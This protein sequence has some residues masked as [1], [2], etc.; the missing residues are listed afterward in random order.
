MYPTSCSWLLRQNNSLLFPNSLPVLQQL[1]GGIHPG[2]ILELCG[3]SGI[4]KS[5]ICMVLV[6]DCLKDCKKCVIVSNRNIP[7]KQLRDLPMLQNLSVCYVSSVFELL[8]TL[9]ALQSLEASLVVIEGIQPLLQ[10]VLGSAN[11]RGHALLNDVKGALGGLAVK[12]AVVYTNGIVS[13]GGGSHGPALGLSWETVPSVRLM[14]LAGEE[15]T[16]HLWRDRDRLACFSVT[17]GGVHME[18]KK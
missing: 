5:Q 10:A 13:L 6:Q 11:F 14:L 4:G 9:A 7:K 8:T 3:P 1:A 16:R 2:K 12:T 18:W 17:D 15:G